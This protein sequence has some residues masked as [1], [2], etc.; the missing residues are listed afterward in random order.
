MYFFHLPMDVSSVPVVEALADLFSRTSV[1][2]LLVLSSSRSSRER[3]RIKSPTL[4]EFHYLVLCRS[5]LEPPHCAARL[6]R[7]WDRV[8]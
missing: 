7:Y 1:P 4:T 8:G 6:S 3:Y 5:Y 2:P